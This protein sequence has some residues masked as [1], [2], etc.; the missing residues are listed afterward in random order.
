MRSILACS[1]VLVLA[2]S[3]RSADEE[4]PMR[5]AKVGDWV[6]YRMTGKDIEGTTKMTIVSKSDKEV[7]YEI[8]AT[9]SFMG[10]K[11][12]APVQR[13]TVD[14]TKPW[15]LISAKNLK[16]N[17]VQLE[18]IS[19]GK[20]TLKAGGKNYETK[21]KKLKSTT[22]AQGFTVVVNYQMWWS[23]DVPVTGLVRLDTAAGEAVTKMEVV[24]SG[25]K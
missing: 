1:L 21:W 14:L 15:D 3:S 17:N 16:E 12:T 9:F 13:Q 8:E 4:N 5:K 25:R 6:E 20:E 7:T 11:Q 19:E 24:A 10:N 23:P 2:P 18:T 22:T